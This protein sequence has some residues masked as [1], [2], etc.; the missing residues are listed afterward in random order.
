MKLRN[1]IGLSLVLLVASVPAMAKETQPDHHHTAPHLKSKSGKGGTPE[2]K[3]AAARHAARAKTAAARHAAR[4]KT[5]AARHVAHAKTA[6]RAASRRR[7]ARRESAQQLPPPDRYIGPYRVVGQREVGSA[8]WYGGWHLGRRTASGERLDAIHATA[9]HRSLPLH[10]LVRV[11][12]LKNGRSVIVA[13]NDRGPVSRGLLIDMS[14]KA[15]EDLDMIHDGI[16]SVAI[17]P[18][19]PVAPQPPAQGR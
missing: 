3:T 9:A 4:V 1:T 5:A 11:T 19:A 15:A 10:S 14:P 6:A 2:G 12:N 16:A 18:I 17:D 7:H 8:A 13:I